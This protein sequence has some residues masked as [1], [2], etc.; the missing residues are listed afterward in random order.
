MPCKPKKTQGQRI[1][2]A[3]RRRP[4][5]YMQMLALGISLCPWKRCR[6]SLQPDESIR[7][8]VNCDGLTTWAIVRNKRGVQ[9]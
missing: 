5:S 7:K 2:A 8:G 6:E 4:L 3:L 9:A 1:A